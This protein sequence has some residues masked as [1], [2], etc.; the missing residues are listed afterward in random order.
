MLKQLSI[1][2]F[3]LIDSLD[4]EFGPGFYA[5]T[6]ETGAGKSILL[7]AIFFCLGGK[8]GSGL[9]RHGEETCCVTLEFDVP[10]SLGEML[11]QRGIDT[12]EKVVMIKRVQSSSNR[13]KFFVN[14]QLVTQ[15]FVEE[16]APH[17]LELHGQ[18]GVSQ[19]LDTSAH[20]EILDRFGDLLPERAALAKA[21]G[22]WRAL[23]KEMANFQKE[24]HLLEREIDYLEV[25]VSE[26]TSLAPQ[27]GEEE[28]LSAQR[29]CLQ[30]REKHRN[31]LN[32]L[33]ATLDEPQGSDQL[34]KARKLLFKQAADASF[35]EI[36]TQLDQIIILREEVV[37]ALQKQLGPYDAGA[38]LEGIEDRLFA[39][40]GAA[41]K[42]HVKIEEL[43]QF[44]RDSAQRLAEL[45]QQRSSQEGVL[46]SAAQA[47][48]HYQHLAA[49]LAT[50]RK[51]IARAFEKK[52][53]AELAHLRMEGATLHVEFSPRQD[54]AASA[55]GTEKVRFVGCTNPGTPLSPINQIASGGELS[56]Y[57]LALKVVLFDKYLKPTIIFD[58]V[59]T[60]IGGVVA[61]AVGERLNALAGAAQVFAITHQPQVAGK[62]SQHICVAKNLSKGASISKAQV[63][64]S[65]QR[66]EELAR[67]ISGHTI[68]P[69][70]RKAAAAL[71][72]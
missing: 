14:D 43:P 30:G 10:T 13:K 7:D 53:A 23:A 44:L 12:E 17:L 20:L 32:E 40:R 21:F 45:Q 66:I 29:L 69:A 6:G 49:S 42:F 16:L 47:E 41:R 15:R 48:A 67:M 36:A 2:N 56:R 70:S 52:V 34:R 37:G 58:E 26:L 25:V 31:L 64:S 19:L 1:R 4:L 38:S 11:L 54:Q 5:I 8:G 50:Q 68:T 39:L 46:N 61:A 33:L 35:A 9:V 65:A 60:G 28:Q 57:I 72:G 3:I 22:H 63:L 18:H 51:A 27:P 55:T 71:L 24:R 62:A 59:D